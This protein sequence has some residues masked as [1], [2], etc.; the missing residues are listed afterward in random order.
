MEYLF[1]SNMWPVTYFLQSCVFGGFLECW[2]LFTILNALRLHFGSHFDI[3]VGALGLWKNSS[4]CISISNF[5]GLDPSRRSLLVGLDHGCVLMTSFFGF[6]WFWA[7]LRLP[8]FDLLVLIVVKKGVLKNKMQ[9]VSQK[10]PGHRFGAWS[11]TYLSLRRDI[12]D[13]YS[14]LVV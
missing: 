1:E 5:R 12:E 4:N 6:L 9:K 8:F 7:V 3:I 14:C 11:P 2:F 10:C 13:P